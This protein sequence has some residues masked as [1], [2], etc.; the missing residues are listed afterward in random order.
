[1]A[2][3][4]SV[5]MPR[6]PRV[7]PDGF[8]Q[9]VL[10]RGDHRE[11]IFHKPA[12]FRAFLAII[13]ETAYRIPM[14]ILA[15]CIMR[16]HFN[17]VLWPY[18]G[19]DLPVFMQRLMNTHI[20]RYLRHYPPASSGHIYQGRYSNP[21]VETSSGLIHV[22]RYV[23]ANALSAGLVKRAE[24]YKWSSASPH[25]ADEGRP[26]LAEWPIERPANWLAYLNTPTPADELNRIQRSARRGAPYGSDEW[27][28]TVAATHGLEST[29]RPRGRP[30]VYETLLPTA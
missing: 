27:V 30:R 29:L 9:H 3:D 16:N 18:V 21:L 8:V 17:L 23:E 6:H 10:N 15:Y 5:G 12:D 22:I 11:T 2:I 7:S 28:Q 1:M 20:C 25:A 4:Q 14:R 13:A 26:V 19:C 24:H